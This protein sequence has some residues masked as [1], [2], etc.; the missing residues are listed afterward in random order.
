MEITYLELQR[1]WREWLLQAEWLYITKWTSICYIYYML[2]SKKGLNDAIHSVLY[3]IHKPLEL[4]CFGERSLQVRRARSSACKEGSPSDMLQKDLKFVWN[5][6]TNRF[7]A[8]AALPKKWHRLAFEVSPGSGRNSRG[9]A[10][11][12]FK[13][14]G[15]PKKGQTAQA[16]KMR[17]HQS[18]APGNER[19]NDES[20]LYRT[21]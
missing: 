12:D 15:H 10:W 7:M 20:R 11:I 5:I 13:I 8:V 17:Q 21:T 19:E 3:P 9:R 1:L 14:G 2:S 18:W 6:S 4:R 16:W